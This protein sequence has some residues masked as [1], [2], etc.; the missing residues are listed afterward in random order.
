MDATQ[1][2]LGSV[3]LGV[4][5]D[6]WLSMYEL[7]WHHSGDDESRGTHWFIWVVGWAWTLAGLVAGA[8]IAPT[9]IRLAGLAHT[10]YQDWFVIGIAILAGLV[11]QLVGWFSTGLV[12]LFVIQVVAND[13]D[14][15]DKA[16]SVMI[17]VAVILPFGGVGYGI[18]RYLTWVGSGQRHVTIAFVGGFAVKMVVIPLIK[19]IVTGTATGWFVRWLRGEKAKAA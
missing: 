11:V 12:M 13:G 9:L 14:I 18:Y 15:S 17:A 3:L 7:P 10:R 2:S 5:K 19:T 8:F 6:V 1:E 16:F 4:L